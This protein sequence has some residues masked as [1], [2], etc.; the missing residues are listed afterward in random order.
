MISMKRYWEISLLIIICLIIGS[1]IV[2]IILDESPPLWD[3]AGHSS[4]AAL[5]AQ[6]LSQGKFVEILNYDTIYPPL[7]YLITAIF[8]LIF[9]WHVD[10]PQYSLLFWLIIFAGSLYSL[11]KTLS[12]NRIVALLSVILALLFPLLAHFTRIYTL[13]FPL[14]AII[15]AC[16]AALVKTKYFSDQKWSIFFGLLVGFA[17]LTKWTAIIFLIAPTL[18]YLL[19]VRKKTLINILLALS[20]ILIIAGPWYFIHGKTV[21]ASSEDTRN[22]I[23]S[24]PYENLLSLNNAFYYF[25]KT[26]DGIS[27]PVSLFILAGI[28]YAIYKKNIFLLLW[29]AVPY[30]ILTF[31]LYSKE[32]RYFLPAFPA[33]AII[34]I[35]FLFS[36]KY[37]KILLPL[38]F[39]FSII[40]WLQ[41]SWHLQI[42]PKKSYKLLHLNNAFGFK[43][44]TTQWLGYGFTY[45][46]AYTTDLDDVAKIIKDDIK[47]NKTYHLIVVPNS[48]FLTVQQLQYY[49]QVNNLNN[50]DYSL[51]P[52]LQ[53]SDWR[54]TILQADYL[55]TKTGEQGPNV[56]NNN[57]GE[58]AE[59]ESK[60]NSKIF[61]NFTLI[62]TWKFSGLEKKSQEM[63]LYRRN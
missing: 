42:I 27:W 63:R 58:I 36:I 37:K 38:L 20:I 2:W 41:I 39:I 56:W 24:V 22:N 57:L 16:F 59:E 4:R 43:K 31:G 12:Q 35:N 53:I 10:I 50:I 55:V 25:N 23:F 61:A 15:T 46:T 26:V 18:F 7:P 40:F 51:S 49:A 14:V 47:K 32:S 8:F 13:D 6:L 1:N 30:L 11:T 21:L 5:Y 45:P 44:I 62:K 33:L 54:N 60:E 29:I 9:G 48:M 17:L 19:K 28:I 3:M 34:T 52:Q